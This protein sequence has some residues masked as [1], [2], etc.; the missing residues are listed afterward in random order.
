MATYPTYPTYTAAKRATATDANNFANGIKLG[1]SPPQCMA[2]RT[3]VG[4]V[5]SA[6]TTLIA[7]TAEDYDN[8][9]MHD[10]A[11]NT[12]RIIAQTAGHYQIDACISWAANTTGYRGIIV[13]LNA[14]GSAA[15]GT[16]LQSN[17]YPTPGSSQAAT[18]WASLPYR[19]NSGDYVEMFGV[20]NS[21]GALGLDIT[22]IYS[23][24]M[25]LRRIGD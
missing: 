15:G 5:N 19:F 8:D 12:S 9:G 1:W 22:T 18:S 4:S 14:A 17:Y 13:R 23:T 20:Q 21:G 11:V 24:F 7:L 10:V 25:A 16:L 3:T 6:T 2:Y